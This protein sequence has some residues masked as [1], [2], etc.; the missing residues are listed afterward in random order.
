[1]NWIRQIKEN[2]WQYLLPMIKFKLSKEIR[3]MAILVNEIFLHCTIRCVNIW[4][5]CITQW[6]NIFQMM[7]ANVT[8]LEVQNFNVIK[9]EK[10]I[11][12][13][14]DFTLQLTFKKILLVKFWCIIKEDYSQLSEKA[15]N[16]LLP[17]QLH[18]CK[19]WIFYIYFKWK[20]ISQQTECRRRYENIAVTIFSFKLDIDKICNNV[21]NAT[22]PAKFFLGNYS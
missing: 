16:I 15:V 20:N 4:K 9:Y 12:I 10:V 5:T 6:T 13:F 18:I 11:G 14:S 17:F 7:S 21:N 22:L 2:N 8:K 19:S 1:M 3:M